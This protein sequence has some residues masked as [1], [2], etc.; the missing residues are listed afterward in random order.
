[1]SLKVF[2]I[3]LSITS[4]FCQSTPDSKTYK[5]GVLEYH[6]ITD[7]NTGE[8]NVEKNTVEYVKWI[9]SKE[10][11][12][13]DILVFP[14][15][16]LNKWALPVELPDWDNITVNPCDNKNYENGTIKRISCATQKSKTYVIINVTEKSKCRDREME[17][18]N[19]TRE[20][21]ADGLVLYNTNVVFD[22]NGTIISKYRKFNLFVDP[23]IFKPKVPKAEVFD[24]DFGVKFG[25]FICFDIMFERPAL[26]IV[27]DLKITDIVFPS[28]WFSEL[29]FGVCE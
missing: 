29:Y 7:G 8:E 9:E 15:S 1:M 4:I 25:H 27:K 28:M 13:L 24:T 10:V 17:E 3:A 26:E 20:C 22:R 19:D 5:A 23:G 18:N 6:P 2:T 21:P 16:T 12:D 14:E 11:Q